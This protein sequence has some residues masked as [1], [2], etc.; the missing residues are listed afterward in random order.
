VSAID[1]AYDAEE[2][3]RLGHEIIDLL[4]DYLRR[5]GARSMPVLPTSQPDG[6]VARWARSFSSASPAQT[7]ALELV[8]RVI[9]ESNHLHHPRYVG[10]QVTAPLPIA[11][12][13]EMISALLNNGMAVFEMGPAAT[14]M[15]RNVIAWMCGRLGFTNGADGILTSG[16]SAGN[17]TALLA[18]R[19]ASAGFDIWTEGAHAGPPLAFITSDQA[20]YSVRRAA[21]IMGLGDGGA[22]SV[23]SDD[24]FRMRAGLLASAVVRARSEGKRV[25]GVIASACSTA[26]GSFDPLEEIAEL[27][28]AH[29][30]WLHVDAAHGAPVVLSKKYRSLATGIERADSVV[31]D[32]HKMM[33]MPAL[34]T[35]VLFRESSRSYDAFAQEA[36]YLFAGRVPSAEWYNG[37]VRTLECTKRMMSLQ[38]YTALAMYGEEMFADYV[39]G[40]IDLAR[41]FATEIAAQPDFELAVEPECNIVCFRHTP[42]EFEGL[43]GKVDALQA[44]LRERVI[45][46]GSYY[47]VQTRLPKGSFLR[48]TIINPL[49]KASDLSELLK[50]LRAAASQVTTDDLSS[51]GRP[52][53][54]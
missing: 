32:A 35:A 13:S 49:T 17:L 45:L 46:E 7:D 41:D 6:A 53:A 39:T 23:P 14:A 1:R 52:A 19:Q 36:S 3:R 22:I 29:G 37:A 18:A 9:R 12:L 10:H 2:F 27:C 20:H 28:R 8:A 34:V 15:E 31:W 38:L 26:T 40:A 43:P 50:T 33:L 21:Q 44:W 24:H 51:I 25:A 5:A 42:R 11:A 4:A 30:L 48:V 47:L 54:R 16:G